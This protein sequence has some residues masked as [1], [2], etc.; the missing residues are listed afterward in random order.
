MFSELKVSLLSS[1]LFRLK[2][3]S[4][5]TGTGILVLRVAG[6]HDDRCVGDHLE[7]MLI[8]LIRMMRVIFCHRTKKPILGVGS[9]ASLM[10]DKFNE[11]GKGG[12]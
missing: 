2:D 4:S 3:L 11:T 8:E 9:K 6:A 7:T 1:H 12:T 10:Q 5:A